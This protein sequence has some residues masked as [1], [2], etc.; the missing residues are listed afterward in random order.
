MSAAMKSARSRPLLGLAFLI[1]A[2][3]AAWPWLILARSAP[4]K[5]RVSTRLS[6]SARTAARGT[7]FWVAAPSARLAAMIWSRMSFMVV[8]K[9]WV[10]QA[11][12]CVRATNCSSL[13]SAAPE[14]IAAR[15]SA[16]PAAIDS[17]TLAA[18]R[19]TPAFRQTVSCAAPGWPR[20]TP[21]S[22]SRDCSGVSTLSARLLVMASPKS[23][24]W[25]SYSLIWPFLSSPT[26]V[27]APRLASSMPSRP[28]TTSTCSAPRRC[29]ARTCMPTR[30]GWN[31]PTRTWG[32]SAGLVSG[33]RMLKMVRTP[34][35]LRTG[36]T[37]FIAGW[38]L[39][40]NMKPM[41]TSAMHRAMASGA[42]WMWMPRASIT[43]ALPLLLETLRPP[44][45]LTLAPAAAATNIA[46]VEMLKVLAPS[47]PVPTM[48]TR[49]LRSGTWTLVENSRIT[50]PAALLS[51]MVSF[52]TRRPVMMAAVMA[53]ESS[54][55]MIMRIRCSISSWKISRCSMVR[56]SACWA[57]MD[58]GWFPGGG[59]TPKGF[60]LRAGR[61]RVRA[62]HG[63]RRS[64]RGPGLRS[65]ALLQEV[66]QQR[67]A[68]LG[69]D[70]FGVELH[71]LDRQRLVAHAHDLA[72]FGPGRDFEHLGATGALDGQRVVAVDRELPGQAGEQALLRG[73]D[74]AGFAVHQLPGPHDGAAERG[75]DALVTQ[76]HAQNRQLAGKMPDRRHRNAGLGRGAGAG[77]EHQALGGSGRKALPRDRVVAKH[78]DIGTEFAQVLD[79]DVGEA[80]VVV[81]HQESHAALLVTRR[82]AGGA[83]RARFIPAPPR[84]VLRRAAARGPCARF[85]SI[86][87]RA[88]NR[89]PPL[90]PPAHAAC[91]P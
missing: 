61:D 75:A 60:A 63:A 76:A 34:S 49:C 14:A 71:A 70:A 91:R 32:A 16:R 20:S 85:P 31:T 24:G 56:C 52:F 29:S 68:M 45:L 36:A 84:R 13:A 53:G 57:V 18:Y 40:A 50:C 5:S 73:V 1:S 33:P 86:P 19:A 17:A 43:S 67:V 72:V 69:Q 90:P 64:A 15:A 39:G 42:R 30:S 25:M 58:M 8:G 3:T 10:F 6:A 23:S 26:S 28:E 2:I 55:F 37:F 47:P 22:M 82:F 38:C 80:V 83:C 87:V 51:P 12:A 9:E 48:S 11:S 62:G 74:D 41:P 81:D 79:D 65:S 21:S 27:A 78:L 44:C 35:S 89:P 54:P 46:Q 66:L 88:P 4:S 7:R 77:R 59:I